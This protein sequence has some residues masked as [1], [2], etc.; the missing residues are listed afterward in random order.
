MNDL[1]QDTLSTMLGE[2]TEI[3]SDG[4]ILELSMKDYTNI[5][6]AADD[7]S[8][9][10]REIKDNLII[11]RGY[12]Y[13]LQ[14]NFS[15]IIKKDNSVEITILARKDSN[16]IRLTY[17]MFI[18]STS[19]K[20][21]ISVIGNPTTLI[22]SH[23]SSPIYLTR[24]VF[25]AGIILSRVCFD[26]LFCILEIEKDISKSVE[27]S[28]SRGDVLVNNTQW[29]MYIKC[30]DKLQAIDTLK[31]S[32][33]RDVP[34]TEL[35]RK[36]LCN[37]IGFSMLYDE[38]FADSG[39]L[40]L[41]RKGT[42][43]VL[44]INFYDKAKSNLEKKTTG[45]SEDELEVINNHLRL[46]ITAHKPYLEHVFNQAQIV[47]RKL[48]DT[49]TKLKYLHSETIREFAETTTIKTTSRNLVISY[50]LLS[51]HYDKKA[52]KWYKVSFS[53][54]LKKDILVNR[55][56]LDKILAF[57]GKI[58]LSNL[59]EWELGIISAWKS[60]EEIKYK[61]SNEWKKLD[62][63]QE[64][65]SV[66]F[67][68]P[69]RLLQSISVLDSVYGIPE[70]M[71]DRYVALNS[72]KEDLTIKEHKELESMRKVSIQN[73]RETRQALS[74]DFGLHLAP[75]SANHELLGVS[76]ENVGGR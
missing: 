54:W 67:K 19:K 45:L 41:Q 36:K 11:F 66:N 52:K 53:R 12:S 27:Q 51:C 30:R 9:K 34:G 50:I 6:Q 35:P 18:H 10:L 15:R 47:A 4:T 58:D 39:F 38:D 65:L 76:Y 20:P 22:N 75:P 37:L 57:G 63:L 59:D 24:D 48:V 61:T 13:T 26:F 69:Y 31:M 16:N 64:K 74:Y 8:D 14:R 43:R 2:D 62:R 32:Y 70:R 3:S 49:K 21:C 56:M 46:D 33:G 5:F 55:L 7:F 42:N 1:I 68:L 73:M 40:L 25:K 17:K 72:K 28:L 29:A 71:Q 44:T 60:G 23:N